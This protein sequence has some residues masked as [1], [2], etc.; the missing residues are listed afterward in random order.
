M[1]LV[2]LAAVEVGTEAGDAGQY[3][4]RVKLR[5][6]RD[7]S[8]HFGV[9]IRGGASPVGAAEAIEAVVRESHRLDARRP[10]FGGD[11]VDAR[12]P[13]AVNLS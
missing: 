10:N 4:L 3:V 12:R 8:A 1:P 6:G 11:G 9:E 7:T 2:P 5:K 13:L